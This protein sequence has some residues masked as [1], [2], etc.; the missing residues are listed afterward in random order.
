MSACRKEK[1]CIE[2]NDWVL[3]PEIPK[4]VSLLDNAKFREALEVDATSD[5]GGLQ[6]GPLP[7]GPLDEKI[8]PII[9][10]VIRYRV[11]EYVKR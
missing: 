3:P 6:V 4:S 9:P 8:Q 2:M 5:S 11:P 10:L 7:A 1:K